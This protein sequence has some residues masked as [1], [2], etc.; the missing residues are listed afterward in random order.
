L[1]LNSYLA[2]SKDRTLVRNL[3]LQAVQLCE[4]PVEMF[5][6]KIQNRLLKIEKKILIIRKAHVEVASRE[7]KRASRLVEFKPETLAL[8]AASSTTPPITHLC[9]Y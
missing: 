4:P 3:F 2:Y 5:L 6:Q 1:N 7:K 8:R 9:L